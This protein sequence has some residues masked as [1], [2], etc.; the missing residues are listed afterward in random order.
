MPAP[1][2]MKMPSSS[3]SPV[4]RLMEWIDEEEEDEESSDE[5]RYQCPYCWEMVAPLLDPDLEG[6][7][8]W[9]CEVC[10]RP[11]LIRISVDYEGERTVTVDRAQ[12]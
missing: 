11:W 8:V 12:N 2:A 6:E 3:R 5:E 1:L 10:C 4:S 9:D 7:L